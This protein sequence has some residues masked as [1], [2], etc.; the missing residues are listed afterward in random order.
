MINLFICY[1][2]MTIF[3]HIM[4]YVLP[5]RE[6]CRSLITKYL[7]IDIPNQNR[8][9]VRI[10]CVSLLY[11]PVSCKVFPLLGDHRLGE[12]ARDS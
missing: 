11:V 9:K 1:T 12:E 6:V 4:R 2:K 5:R 7:H 8:K 3:P 10:F